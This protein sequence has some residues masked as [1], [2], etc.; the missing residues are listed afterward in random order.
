MEP[1]LRCD[2]KL[3]DTPRTMMNTNTYTITGIRNNIA[4]VKDRHIIGFVDGAEHFSQ[5]DLVE[6]PESLVIF[7]G[8]LAEYQAMADRYH[9][10]IHEMQN[11][12]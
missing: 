6:L 11:E 3:R 7:E 2:P 4:A 10:E 5:G 8:Q 1:L 9:G 12:T